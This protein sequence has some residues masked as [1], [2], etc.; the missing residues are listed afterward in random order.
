MNDIEL[1]KCLNCQKDIKKKINNVNI[2]SGCKTI[3]FNKFYNDVYVDK[4][5]VVE[6]ENDIKEKKIRK[7]RSP[8]K[9]PMIKK[10]ICQE[11]DYTL[12]NGNVIKINVK[13]L[14]KT[15]H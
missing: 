11:V 4:S 12:R 14:T 15:C 5:Y 6:K 8:N 3:Y 9:K 10:S 13:K 7:K 2:C 1:L